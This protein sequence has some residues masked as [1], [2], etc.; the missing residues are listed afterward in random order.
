VFYASSN[1][2][3]TFTPRVRLS[4][5]EQ[6]EAAHPQIAVR[7]DGAVAVVWDEPRGDARRVTMRTASGGEFGAA[8]VL[9]PMKSG[10]HPVIVPVADGL[11][12]AW[13]TSE[14]ASGIELLQIGVSAPA[15]RLV[16]NREY[17]FRGRVE[18]VDAQAGT[19]TVNGD[20]VEGWMGAMTMTYQ[21]ANREVL[22]RLKTGDQITASV[23]S[24][25]FQHLYGVAI[26]R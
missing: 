18:A 3:R 15:A 26:A 10:D 22:G 4:S 13:A 7:Q 14:P 2:G 8:V 24:E 17:S 16:E 25:D 5:A 23:R 20:N 1:D 21:V 11:I 12:A 19:V 6:E 9:N